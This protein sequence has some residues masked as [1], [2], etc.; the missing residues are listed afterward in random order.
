LESAEANYIHF[1]D[2]DDLVKPEFYSTL[3]GLLEKKPEMSMA[4]GFTHN[5]QNGI[6]QDHFK[7][8]QIATSHIIN[9]ITTPKI[10]RVWSTSACLWRSSVVKS[11]VGWPITLWEDY[12]FDVA[13]GLINPNIICYPKT[14]VLYR[15]HNQERI[16][17]D[18]SVKNHLS[19]LSTMYRLEELI[20]Q[21]EN[22]PALKWIRK[23]R[24]TMT[25]WVLNGLNRKNFRKP[26]KE[27]LKLSY[28][29]LLL[30]P[31]SVKMRVAIINRVFRWK[32]GV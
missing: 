13:V 6:E 26:V 14:V 17:T 10:N 1:L 25:L 2:S 16:S 8:V 31:M 30:F 11:S 15:V 7:R 4:Y 12:Y 24:K 22:E 9:A 28:K 32:H 18:N 29:P 19:I 23:S 20:E 21:N 3:V 5:Y 27:I